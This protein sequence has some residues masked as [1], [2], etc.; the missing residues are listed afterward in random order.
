M[1]RFFKNIPFVRRSGVDVQPVPQGDGVPLAPPH[2][3]S[4]EN[5]QASLLHVRPES[6]LDVPAVLL[7]YEILHLRKYDTV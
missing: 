6:K 7:I 3:S 5:R 2:L 4:H 1:K